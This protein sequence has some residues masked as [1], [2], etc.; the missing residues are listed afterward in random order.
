M[1]HAKRSPVPALAVVHGVV[2]ERALP[3]ANVLHGIL[4]V[5]RKIRWKRCPASQEANRAFKSGIVVNAPGVLGENVSLWEE[6]SHSKLGA[7]LCN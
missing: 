2:S 4:L 7:F 6:G 5:L 3:M 1:A